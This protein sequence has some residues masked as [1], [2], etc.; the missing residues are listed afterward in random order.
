MAR[1]GDAPGEHDKLM[2][3]QLA[4]KKCGAQGS[5]FLFSRTENF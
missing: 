2:G 5:A 4:Q 3:R 1:Q